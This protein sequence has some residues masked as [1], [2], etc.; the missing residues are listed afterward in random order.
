[1]AVLDTGT[2]GLALTDT[3]YDTDEL[4]L[5]GAAMRDIRIELLSEKGSVVALNATVCG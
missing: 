2:T 3:L 5:P 4:P 1:M